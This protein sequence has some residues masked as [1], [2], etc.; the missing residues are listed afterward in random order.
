MDEGEG[1]KG[2]FDFFHGQSCLPAYIIY[3]RTINRCKT[4]DQNKINIFI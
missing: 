1:I 3:E 4:G 2:I